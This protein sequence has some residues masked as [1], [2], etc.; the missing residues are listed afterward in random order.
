HALVTDFGIARAINE[1]S[2]GVA[3]AS[4]GMAIGTPAYMSPEQSGSGADV[5]SRS[6]IY[7]LACVLYEMLAGRPPFTGMSSVAILMMHRTAPVPSVRALRD[8]VSEE[9]DHVLTKALAKE[10]S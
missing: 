6:D 8:E 2:N 7:S 4:M 9:I 5:D 10:P 3:L 1:A